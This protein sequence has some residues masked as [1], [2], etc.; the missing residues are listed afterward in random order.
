MGRQ[1]LRLP[2]LAPSP[3]R[4]DPAPAVQEKAD[5]DAELNRL[6]G[7]VMAFQ[8]A[9]AQFLPGVGF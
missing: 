2:K 1:S 5:V 3:V 7:L 8:Q 4:P 9:V 6:T